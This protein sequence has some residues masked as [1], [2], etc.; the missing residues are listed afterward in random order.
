[1]ADTAE[2]TGAALEPTRAHAKARFVRMGPMKCRRVVDLVRGLPVSEALAVLRFSP[3]AAAEPVAK[4]IA[5]AAANAENNLGLNPDDVWAVNPRCVY[6]IG[7]G[8]GLE[9]PDADLGGF[10]VDLKA[11]RTAAGVGAAR[12]Q[13]RGLAPPATQALPDRQDEQ[14]ERAGAELDRGQVQFATFKAIIVEIDPRRLVD[15]FANAEVN[16]NRQQ[17]VGFLPVTLLYA[18]FVADFG[19]SDNTGQDQERFHEAKLAGNGAVRQSRR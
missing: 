18:V 15:G 16:G 17:K 9:G 4:V 10:L 6:A 8:Q 3:Q 1:M 13:E 12:R 5:S 7:S 11:I 14:G 2:T 19:E